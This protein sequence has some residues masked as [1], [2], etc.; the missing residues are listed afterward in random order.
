[1]LSCSRA[2][3]VNHRRTVRPQSKLLLTGTPGRDT[4]NTNSCY[5]KINKHLKKLHEKGLRYTAQTPLARLTMYRMLSNVVQLDENE[6]QEI[7]D[8]LQGQSKGK[9]RSHNPSRNASLFQH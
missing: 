2:R 1:M 9:T 3:L 6:I 7:D 5:S 8:I 4:A